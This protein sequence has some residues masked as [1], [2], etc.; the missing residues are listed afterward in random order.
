MQRI[1][2]GLDM[3]GVI[4]DWHSAARFLWNHKFNLDLPRPEDM[5]NRW[6]GHLDYM[7]KEQDAWLWKEGVERGLFR[8]GHVRRGAVEFCRDLDTIADIVLITHRPLQARQD[9]LDWIAFHKIPTSEIHMLHA[10]EDKSNINVDLALDD[11]P[12]NVLSFWQKGVQGLLWDR[13]WNHNWTVA[14]N[15]MLADHYRCKTWEDV[16][17]WAKLIA[18][19]KRVAKMTGINSGMTLSPLGPS[20]SSLKSTPLEPENMTTVIGRKE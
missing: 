19:N 7:T 12:D 20:N 5:W 4:Y 1:R 18:S 8:H 17:S 3:D 6:D 16:L 15:K 10:M 11:K 2:F 9:T 14:G 13:A